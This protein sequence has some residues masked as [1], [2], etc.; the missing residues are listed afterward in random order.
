MFG[1]VCEVSVP[2]TGNKQV[3]YFE[4]RSALAFSCFLTLQY[5]ET[6]ANDYIGYGEEQHNVDKLVNLTCEFWLIIY[7]ISDY[8][9]K[10]TWLYI[11]ELWLM[12]LLQYGMKQ[13]ISRL[14]SKE[15]LCLFYYIFE[16]SYLYIFC[17]VNFFILSWNLLNRAQVDI[18][19]FYFYFFKTFLEAEWF[20]I[21]FF[22]LHRYISKTICC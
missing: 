7:S 18:L 10:Y 11:L 4:F 8:Q 12:Q 21:Q 6:V 20:F 22:C 16:P 5:M 1:Y 2:S 17:D 14:K 3:C 15:L 19:V 13:S 9:M